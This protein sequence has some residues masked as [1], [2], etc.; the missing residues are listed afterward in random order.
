MKRFF[1]I[2]LF[3]VLANIGF[4]QIQQQYLCTLRNVVDKNEVVI[5]VNITG[6]SMCYNY[7][8]NECSEMISTNQ[9]HVFEVDYKLDGISQ[10][11]KLVFEMDHGQSVLRMTEERQDGK[12]LIFENVSGN[13]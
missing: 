13:Q 3:V 2:I 5:D 12:K 6:S 1:C 7:T 9:E 11:S 8:A 4:S 10:K